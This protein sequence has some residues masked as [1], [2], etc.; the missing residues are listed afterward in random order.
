MST[1]DVVT[2]QSQADETPPVF[3]DASGSREIVQGTWAWVHFNGSGTVAI[4]DSFNVS[5]ITDN[6]TGDYTVNFANALPN[7]NYSAVAV[8]DANIVNTGGAFITS[9]AVGSFGINTFSNAAANDPAIVSATVFA[10][11]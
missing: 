1:L 2:I 11:P 8:R 7:A 4:D 9:L 5:S 3:K 10:N 6:G